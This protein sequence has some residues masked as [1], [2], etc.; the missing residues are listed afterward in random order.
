[1]IDPMD[2]GVEMGFVAICGMGL[3]GWIV[4]WKAMTK[5]LDF[6]VLPQ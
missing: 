5:P 4:M 1:M 3:F 6:T 2:F